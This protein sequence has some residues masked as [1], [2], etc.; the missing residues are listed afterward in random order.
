[1]TPPS[2]GFV[3]PSASHTTQ[4]IL[5]AVVGSLAIYTVCGLC[6][7]AWD[8]LFDHTNRAKLEPAVESLPSPAGA[9]PKPSSPDKGLDEA[10]GTDK[11]GRVSIEGVQDA[12][13][14]IDGRSKGATKPA[15]KCMF[16]RT[17]VYFSA[18]YYPLLTWLSFSS[19]WT[20]GVGGG[21]VHERWHT[22][23]STSYWFAVL[24]V[25][26][27]LAHVP[28]T[29]LKDQTLTYKVQMLAHHALSIVCFIRAA[30]VGVGHYFVC[31]DGCCE[32]CTWLL[33]NVFLMK[34]L[35]LD[36][37]QP[38]FA[39]NGFLLWLSY[40]VF[41]LVLFPAWL[42]V[43]FTDTMS[44]PHTTLAF[45]TPV[46]QVLFP[47][48]NVVLLVL[49]TVWFIPISRG[50]YKA[51]FGADADAALQGAPTG[52]STSTT[53]TTSTTNTTSTTA[54]AAAAAAQP[55]TKVPY[56]HTKPNKQS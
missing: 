54:A 37:I 23:L 4:H 15:P 20:Y 10:L 55:R 40:I 29:L 7:M 42:Y 11:A 46:E 32:L 8:A 48:T 45:L 52:A 53:S 30:Y 18:L 1:M 39:L 25:G 51:C 27:N 14:S 47:L 21:S 12:R 24:Y 44:H 34:E 43:Y 49:S 38:L 41:R 19:M 17:D 3:R 31:L 9:N 5:L 26:G 2:D 50:F 36:K 28:V 56:K 13:S 6:V 16:G 33:N 22:V 35:G